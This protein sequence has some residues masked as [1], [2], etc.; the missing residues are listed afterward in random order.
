MDAGRNGATC[1]A[2]PDIGP[3]WRRLRS[4]VETAAR[5]GIHALTLYAFSEENW[6]KRPKSE[7]EFFDAAAEPVI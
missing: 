7:V 1:R 2:W 5:I 4:T 3:E 6:K